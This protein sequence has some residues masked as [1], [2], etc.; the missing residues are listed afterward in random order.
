MPSSQSSAVFQADSP[1][2]FSL[3]AE[4]QLQAIEQ[5]MPGAELWQQRHFAAAERIYLP[6][7]SAMC[8]IYEKAFA[9]TDSADSIL[10]AVRTMRWPSSVEEHQLA[11]GQL[12]Q[13]SQLRKA[14][15]DYATSMVSPTNSPA[16]QEQLEQ[17]V[18]DSAAPLREIPLYQGVMRISCQ[19]L[20][21]MPESIWQS[22]HEPNAGYTPAAV[23]MA[24]VDSIAQR[25]ARVFN[26][27]WWSSSGSHESVDEAEAIVWRTNA[28]GLTA[29]INSH[30]IRDRWDS[31]SR[32]IGVKQSSTKIAF[33]HWRYEGFYGEFRLGLSHGEPWR[34]A[35]LAPLHFVRRLAIYTQ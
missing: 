4:S 10:S 33:P 34:V 7:W 1:E 25:I 20:V 32:G 29:P 5:E 22:L 8:S 16:Q 27:P 18:R 13:E 23:D 11:L 15:R 2:L 6:L 31:E 17:R 35:V 26:T 9:A 24:I 14:W 12:L 30:G 19:Q 3:E 28:Q 21:C